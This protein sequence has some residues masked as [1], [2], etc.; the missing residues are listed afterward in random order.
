VY[1]DYV[2]RKNCCRTSVLTNAKT[3]TLFPT[4]PPLSINTNSNP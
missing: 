1:P 3:A 4:P 2:K